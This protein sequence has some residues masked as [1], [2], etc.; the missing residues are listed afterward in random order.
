LLVN[1]SLLLD[2][3]L[4]DW[5]LL[6]GLLL[7]WLLLDW[8]LLDWLLLDGLLLDGSLKKWVVLFP[9]D[10]SSFLSTDASLRKQTG[11]VQESSSSWLLTALCWIFLFMR[12]LTDIREALISI[13]KYGR[14]KLRFI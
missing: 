3:L 5:M 14:Q 10:L 12:I 9:I 4:L 1:S 13:I 2:E 11:Y 6:D 8:L 7:D